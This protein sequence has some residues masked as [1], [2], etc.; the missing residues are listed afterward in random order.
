MIFHFLQVAQ[1]Y[2]HQTGV[3]HQLIFVGRPH[4]LRCQVDEEN[5]GVARGDPV[6]TDDRVPEATN[7]H[8]VATIQ[9]DLP[10]DHWFAFQVTPDP[11][12]GKAVK[13]REDGGKNGWE[14][15]L[16]FLT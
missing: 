15:C 7:H 10:I 3:Q 14:D 5:A 11:H 4:A 12:L 6:V 8:L 9:Q 16:T 2:P 1:R 13:R